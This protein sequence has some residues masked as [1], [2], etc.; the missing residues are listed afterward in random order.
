MAN[1]EC[2]FKTKDFTC[3]TLIL[4]S[5]FDFWQLSLSV[6]PVSFSAYLSKIQSVKIL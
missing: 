6:M 3:L 2:E 1:E 4:L 5:A